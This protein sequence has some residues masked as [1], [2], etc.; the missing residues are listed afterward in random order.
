VLAWL[1]KLFSRSDGPEV[2]YQP[3]DPQ[4]PP[5]VPAGPP[6]APYPPAVPLERPDVSDEPDRQP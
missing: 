6:T 3:T 2:E 1:K 4:A 5:V